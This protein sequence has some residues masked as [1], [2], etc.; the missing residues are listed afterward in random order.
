MNV[1]GEDPPLSSWQCWSDQSLCQTRVE[2]NNILFC[3]NDWSL[4]GGRL[5]GAQEPSSGNDDC[6]Q[7]DDVEVE[8][9]D[10]DSDDDEEEDGDDGVKDDHALLQKNGWYWSAIREPKYRKIY[11]IFEGRDLNLKSVIKMY[12]L[13]N[14]L[15]KEN[16]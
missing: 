9:Y 13:I 15:S 16:E 8:D 11:K 1:M 4:G 5:G 3:W 7:D 12:G 14:Q 10:V 2:P 6:D